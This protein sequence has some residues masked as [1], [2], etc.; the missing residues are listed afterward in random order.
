M[1]GRAGQGVLGF[2]VSVILS[3]LSR[4]VSLGLLRI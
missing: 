2:I 1:L 4:H 3:L